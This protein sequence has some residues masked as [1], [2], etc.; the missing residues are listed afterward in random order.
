M[1][2]KAEK[3]PAEEKKAEKKLPPSKDGSSTVDKTKKSVETYEMYILKVLKQVH[4]DT[5][6][7]SEAMDIQTAVRLLFPAELAK[8]AVSQG[9]G[10]GAVV[11]VQIAA[12]NSYS[13][14][15]STLMST[16][17]EDGV[18]D[19]ILNDSW[20]LPLPSDD[21]AVNVISQIASVE[22]NIAETDAL[23][24]EANAH[25]E[26]SIK[27]T[28]KAVSVHKDHVKLKTRDELKQWGRIETSI[29]ILSVEVLVRVKVLTLALSRS[30][31]LL[32]SF[33]RDGRRGINKVFL[34]RSWASVRVMTADQRALLLKHVVKDDLANK[35]SFK[36]CVQIAR[37]LS[38]PR[39]EF[40]IAPTTNVH[41]GKE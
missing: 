15:S 8:N 9:V 25:G 33:T 36:D 39:T 5:G 11:W 26:F 30:L 10:L 22:F 17:A 7:S 29:C 23:I 14:L 18:A 27:G 40:R 24:W 41:K 28:Y 16:T 1:A 38:H 31:F 20:Q 13:L 2:P 19:F 4:P 12:E 32:V 37:D 6:I 3:K 34:Y 35:I 21:V